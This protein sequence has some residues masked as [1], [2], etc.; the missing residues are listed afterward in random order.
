M[1]EENEIASNWLEGFLFSHTQIFVRMEYLLRLLAFTAVLSLKRDGQGRL[2]PPPGR[3][4]KCSLVSVGWVPLLSPLQG[5][6]SSGF[7]TQGGARGSLALGWY[8]VAP[9][10]RGFEADDADDAGW[11]GR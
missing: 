2:P 7:V 10:G 3:F 6:V 9:L 1:Q 11:L 5:L 8:G 4:S